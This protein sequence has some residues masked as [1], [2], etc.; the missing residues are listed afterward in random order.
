MVTYL[1][2]NN[3]ETG[4]VISELNEIAETYAGEH[5]APYTP[6]RL[7]VKNRVEKILQRKAIG[8]KW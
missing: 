4:L 3:Y 1:D 8:S 7:R 6:L 5:F 2:K